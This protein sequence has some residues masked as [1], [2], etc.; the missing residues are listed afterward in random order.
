VIIVEG[1]TD[2]WRLGDGAVATFTKNFTREQILL[3]KKKNI[4][5][6]FVF[7]DSDAVGQSK[8]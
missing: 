1:I 8:N 6:A 7:Y 5:E 2:V 4:K 3:L